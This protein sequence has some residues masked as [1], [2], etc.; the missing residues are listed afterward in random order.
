M[1]TEMKVRSNPLHFGG[2]A[3][4]RGF[5]AP[6]VK[7]PKSQRKKEISA[8]LALV[9]ADIEWEV[10]T[11]KTLK[12]VLKE[13]QRQISVAFDVETTG[14]K[15]FKD[16]V[17]VGF[18]LAW[19]KKGY[20]FPLN[21]KYE[22]LHEYPLPDKYTWSE[23]V[24]KTNYRNLPFDETVRL[25]APLLANPDI[26]KLGAYIQFD[27]R[28]AHE[29]LGLTE[30]ESFMDIGP[31]ARIRRSYEYV[32]LKVLEWDELGHYPQEEEDLKAF[33]RETKRKDYI[34]YDQVPI[35][36]MA[37][38]CCSD[39]VYT[40]IIGRR[41]LGELKLEKQ[42]KLAQLEMRLVP[43]LAKMELRGMLVD[44]DYLEELS[45]HILTAMHKI[46]EEAENM[47]GF[48]LTL[49]SDAQ[50][51]TF[52]FGPKD[53]PAMASKK[54][55]I[56]RCLG[57][58]PL[59]QTG[60]GQGDPK[61]SVKDDV[62]VKLREEHPVV[63][64]VTEYR[65]LQKMRNTYISGKKGILQNQKDWIVYP[66]I[67][68]DAAKSGR[69]AAREPSLMNIPKTDDLIRRAF[70]A[71][72]PYENTNHGLL[73]MDSSQIEI[74]IFV[75]YLNN[76]EVTQ[77]IWDGYD[78]HTI[79]ASI[80]FDMDL[81]E[82]GSESIERYLAKT[83]NFAIIYGAGVQRIAGLL[84]QNKELFESPEWKKIRGKEEEIIKKTK[85]LVE[86]YHRELP[87]VSV[88]QEKVIR[89]VI[90][91]GKVQTYFGRERAFPRSF[92]YAALNHIIQGSAADYLKHSLDRA[93]KYLEDFQSKILLTIHDEF[94][95][96]HHEE[97]AL[98]DVIAGVN[99]AMTGYKFKVPLMAGADYTTENW[100]KKE[101]IDIRG[102]WL[103]P[104]WDER[105]AWLE[106]E[107]AQRKTT[108]HAILQEYMEADPDAC[109]GLLS[110]EEDLHRALTYRNGLLRWKDNLAAH[111]EAWSDALRFSQN[112]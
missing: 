103:Q 87:F 80:M 46:S 22:N 39:V 75:H 18:G 54:I 29:L 17:I 58:E 109:K 95:I 59:E 88:L 7:T 105:E 38:Y 102:R 45:G 44:V 4:P 6:R 63:E 23:P 91:H 84:I 50:V 9:T 52:L 64:L 108:E 97:D 72:H 92:A 3:K 37:I 8:E 90:Q 65:A 110:L 55:E 66:D 5:G 16:V 85:G 20:Y 42:V 21:H 61:P 70:I 93:E 73:F 106:E 49:S 104:D 67:V 10:V 101:A 19:D 112:S 27:W 53:E 107:C 43:T 1:T 13:A 82:V 79:T 51:R 30:L 48:P 74:R 83:I 71:N 12:S 28:V 31:L 33:L 26:I 69:L 78:F 76:P 14:T 86:D 25:L 57:L 89:Y 111:K 40:W 96:R 47:L 11:K 24:G 36:I 62:L 81:D 77:M 32:G 2:R 68:T 99:D 56:P 35:E 41:Y 98:F 94:I 15:L 100:S 34:D 60:G